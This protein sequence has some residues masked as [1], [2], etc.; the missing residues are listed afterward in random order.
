MAVGARGAVALLLLSAA[1]H[2]AVP[3]P[4][5]GPAPAQPDATAAEKS[6]AAGVAAFKARRLDEALTQAEAAWHTGGL[7]DALE[8]VAVAALQS[9]RTALAHQAYVYIAELPAAPEPMRTRAARQVEA[10]TKQG[11]PVSPEVRPEGAAVRLDGVLLGT[12]PLGTPAYV[13][14]GAHTLSAEAP[15]HQKGEVKLNVP[16][17]GPVVARLA[18]T[19][20]EDAPPLAVAP[21]TAAPA[22]A[23]A[24]GS[25]APSAAVPVAV[26][27]ASAS[28]G[29][30]A[31][32]Q[33][34]AVPRRATELLP[35][36]GRAVRIE[37]D[38]D[39]V[40]GTLRAVDE[41]AL[42]VG[43]AGL[44]RRVPLATIERLSLLGS[45]AAGS[46]AQA[47]KVEELPASGGEVVAVTPPGRAA[48]LGRFAGVA[49]G[50]LY[51]ERPRGIRCVRWS[52]ELLV[53]PQPEAAL[54]Q[55]PEWG[56]RARRLAEAAARRRGT[57]P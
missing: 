13:F 24:P 36:V 53:A 51:L 2:G 8:L 52:K 44:T 9:G 29:P 23:P 27:P 39:S 16:R 17:S 57:A 12:A 38:G 19:P 5:L 42:F 30:P 55:D 43:R 33:W 10:L 20:L 21:S 25:V 11:R 49:A 3:P 47:G 37:L 48:M 35:L 1:A 45:V 4:Q 18:L 7:P 34:R 28:P 31:A 54:A 14:P 32:L 22:P 26:N 46:S 6:L 15:G 41:A 40:T 50:C 56:A